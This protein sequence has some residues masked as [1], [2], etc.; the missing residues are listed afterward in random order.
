MNEQC[1]R[2]H[3][4]VA[5]HGYNDD[6]DGEDDD[7]DGRNIWNRIE[8]KRKSNNGRQTEREFITINL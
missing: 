7:N 8:E 2:N 6:D 4:R 3:K 1:L 5:K